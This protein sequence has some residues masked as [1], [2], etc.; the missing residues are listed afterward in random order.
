MGIVR[1]EP[2][3]SAEEA[4]YHLV[5]FTSDT[6]WWREGEPMRP[7]FLEVRVFEVCWEERFADGA[8]VGGASIRRSS[9][10][11]T[12]GALG[13]ELRDADGTVADPGT[14]IHVES[15]EMHWPA[16]PPTSTPADM[17]FSYERAGARSSM[18]RTFDWTEA[19]AA[20]EGSVKC[21][22]CLNYSIGGEDVLAH[23]CSPAEISELAAA[24]R[25]VVEIAYEIMGV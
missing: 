24:F 16:A 19:R 7:G 9:S 3:P 17:G 8:N 14:V 12:L 5:A 25:R 2:W 22:G 20:A 10:D 11:T 18:E 1:I 23:A 13:L 4:V 6:V 21:D 15:H